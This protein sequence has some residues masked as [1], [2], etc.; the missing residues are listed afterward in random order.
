MVAID[1]PLQY[2]QRAS[3][4]AGFF[5]AQKQRRRARGAPMSHQAVDMAFPIAL[6]HLQKHVLMALAY[7]HNH[8]KNRCDPAIETVAQDC[9][10]SK[11]SVKAS[12]RALQA[13]GLI[14][15]TQRKD[16]RV[17]I[18]NFYKLNFMTQVGQDTTGVGQDTTGV[19][20]DTP[21]L[22]QDTTGDKSPHDPG[23]GQDTP[24]KREAE[25]GRERKTTAVAKF[26]LPPWIDR[27]AWAGF[28]EM[29]NK[30]RKPMTDRARGLIVK[31]LDKLR[32]AGNDVAT[33]LNRSTT[34]NWT[35]VYPVNNEAH[36]SSGAAPREPKPRCID[37]YAAYSG[38]E[39]A[40]EP[41][42]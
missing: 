35:D 40:T 10:M 3:H 6:P 42:A 13:M 23:V 7:R 5:Y 37:P 41:A 20:Q 14:E 34:K 11:S 16:G 27:E 19:G 17:H 28:E 22:G 39:Y 12:L 32:A 4:I 30:I 29:R 21:H 38:S 26:V 25:S 33:C 9:G 15:A 18:S 24:P 1:V 8:L 31:E 2:I 36:F